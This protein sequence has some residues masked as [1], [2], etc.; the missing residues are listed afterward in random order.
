MSVKILANDGI[1]PSGKEQ[2]E[3]AG[4]TVVTET[5]EQ[6]DLIDAINKEDYKVLLVRSATKVRENLIDACPGL[7][8]IGRGGVGMDN[9]DVEYARNKGIVVFNTPASSSQAVAELVMAHMFSLSRG[10]YDSNRQMPS[11]GASEF[12]ALKKKY[13][14]GIELRGK[15]LGVMGFGRIGQNVA[16]YALGCGMKVIAYDLYPVETAIDLGIEDADV[17]VKIKTI[18]KEEVL[19]NSDFITL[20]IPAQPDGSAAIGKAEFDM[21]KDGA[22]LVNAARGGVVDEDAM[23]EALKSGK[24]ANVGVDVFVN[25]PTPRED[26][27]ALANA[28]LS[29]HIGAATVEAQDRIGG[30]I[31]DIIIDHYNK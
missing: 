2:L 3:N 11:N 13:A 24:L 9:I 5:V 6:D 17:K 14:K 29:P 18:S 27:L 31:A 16:K 25:E 22:I 8:M 23:I 20:H 7:E 1:S 4:Y 30:E 12:K 10:L 28:S 21:M 19:Q 15:T 26:V